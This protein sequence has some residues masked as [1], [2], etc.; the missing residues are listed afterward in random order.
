M[1]MLFDKVAVFFFKQ[2]TA[3]EMRISDWS[4]DVCSSDLPLILT[5]CF[6]GAL[7]PVELEQAIEAAW[8]RRETITPADADLRETVSRAIEL[9]DGGMARVAEP[10]GA[11]GWQVNQ[12]RKN[13]V[14]L[15]FRLNA[16]PV[17]P[18]SSAG[19]PA[20]YQDLPESEC[21]GHT[22][23]PETAFSVVT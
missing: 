7:M 9:L 13:A 3:Y 15:S 23:F 1:L 22:P 17:I 18:G 20:F 6:N 16:N 8:E 2:K 14:L 5:S 10:D 21:S 12:W 4:S 11:G 19:G